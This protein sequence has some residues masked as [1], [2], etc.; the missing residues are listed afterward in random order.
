MYQQ[1]YYGFP[2]EG[3]TVRFLVLNGTPNRVIYVSARIRDV[4]GAAAISG[5]VVLDGAEALDLVR[6]SPAYGH[7][8]EWSTPRLVILAAG[9]GALRGLLCYSVAEAAF[10]HGEGFD[11]LLVAYPSA[12]PGDLE[13]LFALRRAGADVAVMVDHPQHVTRLAAAWSRR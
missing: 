4:I 12:E 8:G 3:N 9:D 1:Y 7:L 11:E 6:N 10:L 5:E 2:V 13:Q